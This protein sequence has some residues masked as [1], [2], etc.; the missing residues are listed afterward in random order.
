MQTSKEGGP[1][2][3]SCKCQGPE[4]GT[5]L[6]CAKCSS[7]ASAPGNLVAMEAGQVTRATSFRKECRGYSEWEGKALEGCKQRG[8]TSCLTRLR[9]DRRPV[10]GQIHCKDSVWPHTTS[11]LE[12][13][14]SRLGMTSHVGA[15]RSS[16][17]PAALSFPGDLPQRRRTLPAQLSYQVHSHL[18]LETCPPLNIPRFPPFHW[19][20]PSLLDEEGVPR[21][22]GICHQTSSSSQDPRTH[23]FPML[24]LGFPIWGRDRE[25][26]RAVKALAGYVS[27]SEPQFPPLHNRNDSAACTGF[28]CKDP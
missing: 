27:P 20:S 11:S 5:T 6:V 8:D 16:G 26:L 4:A 12:V 3:R 23:P 17:C 15:G 10:S 7:E 2:R 24:H 14:S 1:G 25:C 19:P 22:P 13:S 18:L 9:A 21:L 28:F